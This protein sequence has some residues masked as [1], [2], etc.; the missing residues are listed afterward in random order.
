[1]ILI[2]LV[3]KQ[4]DRESA[5][6]HAF[7]AI[8]KLEPDSLLHYR[9]TL[10][11][12]SDRA[13]LAALSTAIGRSSGWPSRS[14]VLFVLRP[15]PEPVLGIVAASGAVPT[16][17]LAAQARAIERGIGRLRYFDDRQARRAAEVLAGNLVQQFGGDLQHCRFKVIPRGGLI[18]LGMLASSL[19]LRPEQ[20]EEGGADSGF[21]VIVDDCALSGARFG[22]FIAAEPAKQIVFAHLCSPA[23]FRRALATREPRVVASIAAYNLLEP[24]L[25]VSSESYR[26]AQSRWFDRLGPERYVL[27]DC[28]RVCFPWNEPDR[29]IWN[30]VAQQAELAWKIVPP[31]RCFK[32]V[33]IDGSAVRIQIQPR[34]RGPFCPS[35][36]VVFGRTGH[37]TIVA[38]LDSGLTYRLGGSASDMWWALLKTGNTEDA[39]GLLSRMYDVDPEV[40][41]SDL[42]ELVRSL[43]EQGL[44]EFR[45]S[46]R[47]RISGV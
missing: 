21:L 15:E 40:L 13:A 3:P 38:Q 39:Q 18:V 20:L 34:G 5:E 10:R 23:S 32:R 46:P 36:E 1:M 11:L 30:P 2:P 47:E 7:A 8:L 43:L 16:D 14:D 22:S 6:V 24:D 37:E 25:E 42:D 28:E 12:K 41:R 17:L 33:S 45:S 19:D 9:R 44:M 27:S 29:L 4:S 35:P 26:V 31:Q